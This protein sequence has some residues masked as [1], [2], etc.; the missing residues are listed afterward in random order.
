MNK[1]LISAFLALLFL[2]GYFG[3]RSAGDV[4]SP[5]STAQAVHEITD[6]DPAYATC[7][8]HIGSTA[9]KVQLFPP[10]LPVMERLNLRIETTSKSEFQIVRAW[11]E[12]RDMDMGRHELLP[13]SLLSADDALLYTG[14]IPLCTVNPAMV[15]QLKLL[16]QVQDQQHRLVFDLAAKSRRN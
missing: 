6:C 11:F 7:P 15:W 1:L 12:G 8:I 14:V 4:W 16:I 3:L 10:G 2:V 13:A 5:D 9:L